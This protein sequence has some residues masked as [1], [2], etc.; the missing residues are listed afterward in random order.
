MQYFDAPDQTYNY[1][2]TLSGQAPILDDVPS[3]SMS[4]ENFLTPESGQSG[5]IEPDHDKAEDPVDHHENRKRIYDFTSEYSGQY[6]HSS[7]NRAQ[8]SSR[9]E[10]CYECYD[11]KVKVK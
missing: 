11:R 1:Y 6:E 9:G 3:Y 5:Q 8:K 7:E 4:P 10:S 2:E